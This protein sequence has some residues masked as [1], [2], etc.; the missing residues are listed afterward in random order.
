MSQPKALFYAGLKIIGVLT[1]IWSF[2]HV[3]LVISQFYSVYNQPDMVTG[4]DLRYFR[5]SL[6]FQVIYP[7]ILFGIGITLL[8]K[9]ENIIRFAFR[10]SGEEGESHTAALFTLFMKL[11]GLILMI[12]A[13]PKAFQIISNIMFISSVSSLNTSSQTMFIIQNLAITVINLLLGYYLL[14]SGKI[15]YNLGFAKQEDEDT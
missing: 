5:F 13:I 1:I 7:I 9:G 8:K 2:T 11:A 10:D 4:N 12:Y 3:V 6:I 15:F 14:R